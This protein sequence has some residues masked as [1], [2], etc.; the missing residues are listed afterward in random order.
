MGSESRK[1]GKCG[2]R[3]RTKPLIISLVGVFT[4]T[5]E[6]RSEFAGS[7]DRKNPRATYIIR[8]VADS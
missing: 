1:P 2:L 6:C 8:A 5:R 4:P 7:P 3:S